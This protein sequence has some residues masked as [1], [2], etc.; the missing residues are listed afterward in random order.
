[1]N[2]KFITTQYYDQILVES[3]I[4]LQSTD[5]AHHNLD[6]THTL[7]ECWTLLG[8]ESLWF[9]LQTNREVDSGVD[10]FCCER[11]ASR[12]VYLQDWDY[13]SS[14]MNSDCTSWKVKIIRRG[15]LEYHLQGWDFFSSVTTNPP[16][17]ETA[18]K[19][20]DERTGLSSAGRHWQRL[21]GKLHDSK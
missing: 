14:L 8:L 15:E 17:I 19:K 4:F 7:L 12:W 18:S 2:S 13:I 6:I 3:K 1:M 21:T 10:L 20:M 5:L 11:T 9:V 16:R